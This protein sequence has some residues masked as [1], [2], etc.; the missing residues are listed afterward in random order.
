MLHEVISA[1]I[2]LFL[3]L[4]FAIPSAAG[5]LLIIAAVLG[6]RVSVKIG[7]DFEGDTSFELRFYNNESKDFLREKESSDGQAKD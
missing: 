1:A 2:T 6:G 4:A 7:K 5:T 3:I